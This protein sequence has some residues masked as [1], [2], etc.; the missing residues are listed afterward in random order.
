MAVQFNATTGIINASWTTQNR[1]VNPAAGQM[2]FNL[3]TNLLESWNGYVWI[4]AGGATGFGT[5]IYVSGVGNVSGI[6]LSGL[7]TTSGNL[8]LGGALNLSFAPYIGVVT[9]NAATF[10][11]LAIQNRLTDANAWYGNNGQIL[12]STG[13]GILWVDNTGSLHLDAPIEIGSNIP[14]TATFTTLSVGNQLIDGT[15][16]AGTDGQFLISTGNSIDWITATGN[17][18]LS[19]PPP[20]GNVTPNLATFSDVVSENILTITGTLADVTG[21]VGTANQILTS[22]GNGIRWVT[23]LNANSTL[24]SPPPLGNIVPNSATFTSFTSTSSISVRGA[25]KDSTGSTGNPNQLLFSTG[26]SVIWGNAEVSVNLA[27]PPPIGNVTPNSAT[28]TTLTINDAMYDSANTTG[29]YGQ[30]LQGGDCKWTTAAGITALDR[31]FTYQSPDRIP[32]VIYPNPFQAPV[33]ISIMVQTNNLGSGRVASAWI[34]VID[35]VSGNVTFNSASETL[36]PPVECLVQT[37]VPVGASYTV[38]WSESSTL[39]MWAELRPEGGSPPPKPVTVTYRGGGNTGGTVPDDPT[40]YKQGNTVTVLGPGSMVK[41]NYQFN[42]WRDESGTDY[43]PGQTFV[44]M[45]NVILTALWYGIPGIYYNGAIDVPGNPVSLAIN[46]IEGALYVSIDTGY[47]VSY[48]LD[49]SNGNLVYYDTYID[50]PTGVPT[51][52]STLTFNPWG[53]TVCVITND[54]TVGIFDVIGGAG[55]ELYSASQTIGNGNAEI[56]TLTDLAYVPYRQYHIIGTGNVSN[57]A[58]SNLV[59]PGFDSRYRRNGPN[60]YPY[61][62]ATGIVCSPDGYNAYVSFAQTPDGLNAAVLQSY[63]VQSSTMTVI[64]SNVSSNSASGVI[65]SSDG[66]SIYT[67]NYST[68]SI[69]SYSRETNGNITWRQNY[70]NTIAGSNLGLGAVVSSDGNYVYCVTSSGNA[71]GLAQFSRDPNTSLLTLNDRSDTYGNGC[72]NSAYR[73]TMAITN[74]GQYVFVTGS[75]DVGNGWIQVWNTVG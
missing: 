72:P 7:V 4:S 6:S 14:N 13:N 71:S 44:I 25:L 68:H 36:A 41:D 34:T 31:W 27:S 60:A 46:E 40:I 28:F 26:N 32:G 1:P 74:N 53:N 5:V 64:Q 19:T 70:A 49:S 17:I 8:T 16:S 73:N 66:N 62:N 21:N 22:T 50:I 2:G 35:E 69:S 75:S 15:G 33:F 63:S 61:V 67:Y 43:V 10:T 30:Y 56:A 29:D 65:C 45:Q 51:S 48:S 3:T 9:P 54:V 57:G 52:G 11:T 24:A 47:I 38:D 42:G 23:P 58:Y 20:I 59:L 18:N 55:L 37:I 12:S 39:I